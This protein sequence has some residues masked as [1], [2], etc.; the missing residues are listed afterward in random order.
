MQDTWLIY[1]N[2]KWASLAALVVLFFVIN[3]FGSSSLDYLRNKLRTRFAPDDIVY[4]YL[5][6]NIHRS[7]A[8]I[9]S[10][11]IFIS[12]VMSLGLH[13]GPTRVLKT[14]IQFYIGYH[15]IRLGLY[16]ADAFGMQMSRWAAKTE[17]SLDDQLAPLLT[18]SLKILVAVLGV[19]IVLQNTG[20]N[21]LSLVAG[22]GLGG[23]AL[24]LAAQETVANLFGSVTIIADQPFQVGDWIKVGDTEGMVEDLGFRSTRIRT[25]SRSLVS[26]P[27]AT[28]AKEKIENL[29]R[30]LVRPCNHNVGVEY[31]AKQ[32][33][34]SQ[35][36]EQIR[37]LLS[38]HEDVVKDD[39]IVFFNQFGDSSLNIRVSFFL[40]IE[41]PVDFFEAQQ[42]IL[43]EIMKI[44][45]SVGM[46][47]AFP[48]QTLHVASLPSPSRSMQ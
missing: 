43:F 9:I 3:R 29:G 47:F 30:R 14:L 13:E 7:T 10:A 15:G 31:G 8:A 18:K 6:L 42:D 27:N 22:L 12:G 34:L 20:V 19:L 24:A 17:S 1:P 4:M 37:Y 25:L 23:L 45:Q 28:M 46:S 38:R 44:V 11:L 39:I 33:Q 36:V 41:Q 26:I 35:A 40:V 16:A 48:T 21:V 2:W 5:G 32:E